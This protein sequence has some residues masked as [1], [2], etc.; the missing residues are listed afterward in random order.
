M[1]QP[2]FLVDNDRSKMK[3]NRYWLSPHLLYGLGWMLCLGVI[4]FAVLGSFFLI[5]ANIHYHVRE[6]YTFSGGG[7]EAAASLV[8]MLPKT[9]PY[10]SV[11][12][13]EVFWDGSQ[14]TEDHS[15]VDVLK[16][17]GE[18]DKGDDLVAIIE[19]DVKLPQK[20]LYWVAPVEDFQ[21]L[22]QRGI[23]SDSAC[24]QAQADILGAG[25]TEKDAYD[26]YAFTAEYLTYS[27]E[28]ADCTGVS[29]LRAFEEGK[30]ACAGYARVMTALCRASGIPAQMVL[31]LVYPDPMFKLQ[32]TSFPN[33]PNEAH[34]WVEYH[35]EG[36][37]KMADPTWGAKYFKFMQFDRNDG[38]HLVYGEVEEILDVNGIMRGWAYEQTPI[39]MGGKTSFRYFATSDLEET[40]FQPAISIQRK[41][42]GRWLNTIIIWAGLVWFLCRNRGR[43]IK[44]AAENSG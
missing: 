39:L 38:R 5:P 36:S 42:D 18:I 7:E 6:E 24:I 4:S 3:S 12:D 9:G 29:A 1:G 27:R 28:Q 43:I 13:L 8:V 16:L 33:N 34:A 41:W 14:T 17:S 40:S 2:A 11:D 10:Q 30:C 21:L 15:F 32:D 26:V 19:Y 35:S 25:I 37:W 20:K 44:I 31:G 23:E 22:P